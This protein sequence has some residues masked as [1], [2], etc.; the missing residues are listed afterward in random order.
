MQDEKSGTILR[1]HYVGGDPALKDWPSQTISVGFLEGFT[2]PDGHGGKL[3][4]I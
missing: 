2:L 1:M 3:H 4:G